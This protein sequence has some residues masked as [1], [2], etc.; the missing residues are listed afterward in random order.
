[1]KPAQDK[2]R[3]PREM[4]S[5]FVQVVWMDD[6]AHR[7]STLGVL[8]DVNPDGLCV[9]LELPVPKGRKVLIHTRGI[10]GPGRVCYCELGDYGYRIGLEFSEGCS[11]DREKWQPKHLLKLGQ[12]T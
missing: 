3:N 9:S 8:E 7:I 6:C 2:R 12:M 4:C 10:K 11:W 5:D 1:M